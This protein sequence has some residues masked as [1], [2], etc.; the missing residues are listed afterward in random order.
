MM[1]SRLVLLRFVGYV[2][3]CSFVAVIWATPIGFPNRYT[4]FDMIAYWSNH[5]CVF[6]PITTFQRDALS[7]DSLV[8]Q[9]CISG[10]QDDRRQTD[11]FT[12][13]LCDALYMVSKALCVNTVSQ[14]DIA[15]DKVNPYVEDERWDV[16]KDAQTAGKKILVFMTRDQ[17]LCEQYCLSS[18]T[19]GPVCRLLVAGV[20]SYMRS[21]KD[22]RLEK[23]NSLIFKKSPDST[24]FSHLRMNTN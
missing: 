16:C 9:P 8:L 10:E 21:S 11:D 2:F 12:G 5:S 20:V 6:P 18:T 1:A 7:T 15:P 22:F 17:E 23:T 19:L 24:G 4:Y 14:N 3:V 13:Q